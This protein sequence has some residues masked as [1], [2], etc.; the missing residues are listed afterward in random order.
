MQEEIL[1]IDAAIEEQRVTVGLGFWQPFK[2]VIRNKKILWRFFLGGMLFLWQNASGI[3]AVNYYSPTIFKTIGITGTSTS[4]LTTGVFGV[5]KTIVT[6]FWL[7]ILIDK[8]GRRKLLMWGALGGSICM[9][10]IAAYIKV[11]DPSA[12]P[13][14]TLSS[15]GI[16]AMAFFYLWTI[17]YTP[18]WNGTPWVYNSEMH[19]QAVRPLA[20]AFAAANN[21]FWNFIIA[22]FT[23]QMFNTM[24]FGVYMFFASLMLCSAV[25][26]YFLMP[27]TKGVPLEAMDRLFDRRLPARK[28]HKIVLAELR[29]DDEQFRRESVDAGKLDESGYVVEGKHIE[30]V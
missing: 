4:L 16:S 11:A 3:N 9:W 29:R 15:G 1:A 21:W 18:S 26:V 13:T 2:A 5:V 22:R 10:Y 24:G 8:L 23:P 20:Q 25:F 17:C 14:K 28:A 30:E 6:L 12:H 7:F 19:S 27:E